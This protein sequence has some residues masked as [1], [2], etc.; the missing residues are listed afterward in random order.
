MK[1]REAI[2]MRKEGSVILTIL[3][4]IALVT[5]VVSVSATAT[6]EATVTKYCANNYSTV[7]NNTTLNYTD[8]KAN[9][10][11]V[12]S[13]GDLWMQGATFNSSDP[14]G[15]LTPKENMRCFYTHNGTYI[16]NLTDA[17][18]GMSSGDEIQILANDGFSKW[19]NYTNVYETH[20]LMG[21][22]VLTWWDNEM[23][24]VPNFTYGMRLYFYNQTDALNF[25]DWDMH[26]SLAPWYWHYYTNES[27][28]WPSA[29]GL[30]V[31]YVDRIN[32][33]PPHRHD[34]NTTG[35]T[36]GW[37]FGKQTSSNPPSAPNDPNTE[38]DSTSNIADDDGTFQT[39]VTTADGN[40]AAHRF[41]FS[42][43]TNSAK[44]GPIADI[45]TLNV[46][47]NGKGGHS[48]SSQKNGTNLYIY[49]YST[50]AGYELL[51]ASANTDAEVYLT[52]E[53]TNTTGNLS[54][55]IS[56]TNNVTVLAKQKNYQKSNG[57]PPGQGV[58]HIATDY[59]NMTVRHH[60]HN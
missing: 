44:D 50:G 20:P 7:L 35:D 32:I 45:E 27:G 57:P 36:T 31:K 18:G 23:G 48:A 29:K 58:S 10:T 49:N 34:F 55:Y 12:L 17:V 60:H 40:Y 51:Q 54:D 2:K 13:V 41:N 33:Y 38:F 47:W 42:I 3:L 26:E 43:D 4:C 30:S 21:G 22:M 53:K 8:M 1:K 14:W 25:T 52:G 39:D 16:H 5:S 56:S 19:F 59:V 24:Y 15:N 37:A 46:T 9:Y 11:N 28:S 6:T